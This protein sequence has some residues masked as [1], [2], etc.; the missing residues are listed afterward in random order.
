MPSFTIA[1][2]ESL[3]DARLITGPIIGIQMPADWT[4]AALSFAT[5]ETSGGTFAPVFKSNGDELSFQASDDRYIAIHPA[6]LAWARGKYLKIRSG[7]STA[8]VNQG[9][10]RVIEADLGDLR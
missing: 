5:S 8:A 10:E 6:D 2:G 9:A 7:L 3:S 4:A 1:N